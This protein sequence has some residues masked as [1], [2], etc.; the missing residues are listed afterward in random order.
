MRS[1]RD[2]SKRKS[3]A[4]NL[5]VR[6]LDK[7]V[8]HRQLHEAFAA[9]GKIASVKIAMDH[10]GTSKGYGFV[11]F[12]EVDAANAALEKMNGA[13]L[14][15][16]AITVHTF[17]GSAT[18]PEGFTNI[19]IKH[20]PDELQSEGALRKELEAC[21][22][23]VSFVLQTDA[24]SR[25]FALCEFA[26]PEAAAAAVEKLHGRD[27]RTEDEK[28]S[29]PAQDESDDRF[30]EYKLFC[31]RAQTKAERAAELRQQFKAGGG[32]GRD[33]NDVKVY[34]RNLD[35]DVTE[36]QLREV[37][38]S[39]GTIT[40][41]RI[42]KDGDQSRGFGFVCFQNMEQAN[43]AVESAA[44]KEINGKEIRVEIAEKREFGKGGWKGGGGFSGG[45]G[46]GAGKGKAKGMGKGMG[47]PPFGAAGAS[48]M[49]P[50]MPMMMPMMGGMGGMGG[51]MRPSTMPGMMSGMPM[52]GKGMARPPMMMPGMMMG[53]RPGMQMFPGMGA[54]QMPAGAG[55]GPRPEA[56]AP[57]PQ[58][59]PSQPLTAEV[60][61]AA[62]PVL[63]KQMLGEKIFAKV[64]KINPEQAGKITGMM[65]EL[66]NSELL[67]L[68]DD[69]TSLQSKVATATQVL[70]SRAQA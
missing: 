15:G 6:N 51:M 10:A 56:A 28:A 25:K 24:R 55:T 5:T 33:H 47:F 2:P 65:L 41:A 52:M 35:D 26:K 63:Q 21:G 9:H 38:E 42:P 43:K 18:A 59:D 44:G 36:E 50:R 3:G 19:Y 12:E 57:S 53:P 45:G 34:V 4:G 29:Q 37:F 39:Y 61:A 22:E 31:Q 14:G 70:R 54:P 11:Q 16:Q 23:I 17:A 67:G 40:F 32:A 68:L 13:Q 1:N 64:Y 49:M 46:Y 48:P 58:W 8:T 30:P 66:H 20:L 7:S 60:L 69:P 27:N 62:P